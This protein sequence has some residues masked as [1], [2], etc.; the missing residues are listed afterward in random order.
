VKES[1]TIIP[2]HLPSMDRTE[3]LDSALRFVIGRIEEQAKLDGEPLSNEQ[4]LLL[5]YLPSSAPGTWDP[6]YP[7]LVPRNINLEQVCALGKAAYQQDSKMNHGSL[8]WEFAFA[9]F[10]LNQHPMGGLLQS[11]GMK[12][13]RPRWDGLRLIVTALLPLVAV[14]L[15][16][17]NADKS[18]F[19]SVGIGLG[20]AAI[21]LLMFFASRRFEKQQLKEEIE[22]CRLS[23][24]PK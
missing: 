19:R 21:M 9:V 1:K 7:V 6:R 11:A 23:F 8:N 20:C 24:R 18:L 3:D 4:R 5:D 16:V 14:I 10:T 12:L 22:K 15:L 2:D 13:R 17:W